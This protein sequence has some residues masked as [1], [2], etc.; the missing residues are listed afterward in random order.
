MLARRDKFIKIVVFF[1]FP[2]RI[3]ISSILYA[4]KYCDKSLKPLQNKIEKVWRIK[5]IITNYLTNMIKK[6]RKEKD[7]NICMFWLWPH[8]MYKRGWF[9]LSIIK[10]VTSLKPYYNPSHWQ[11]KESECLDRGVQW[12]GDRR[13]IKPSSLRSSGGSVSSQ[14]RA[15]MT[16]SQLTL[17]EIKSINIG[18][19]S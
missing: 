12:E 5:K 2:C 3:V 18:G 13:A 4:P 17:L 11:G 7:F 16:L 9:V 8:C 19:L 6:K 15:I 10:L 1:R 14:V